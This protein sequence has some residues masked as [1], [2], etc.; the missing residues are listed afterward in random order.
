[1]RTPIMMVS[2]IIWTM[3]MMVMRSPPRMKLVIDAEGNV[4]F[5]DTDGDGVPD[6][7]DPDS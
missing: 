3:M 2:P 1:M 4:T 5:P 7:L 6:Y